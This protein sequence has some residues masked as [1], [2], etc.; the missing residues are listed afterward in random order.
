MNHVFADPFEKIAKRY[1][2][3]NQ[4]G[5][6]SVLTPLLIPIAELDKNVV[7]LEGLESTDVVY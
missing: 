6:E 3:A 1:G 4:A 2:G 5:F 7:K